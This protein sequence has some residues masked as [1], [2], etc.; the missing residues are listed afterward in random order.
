MLYLLGRRRKASVAGAPLKPQLL[1]THSEQTNTGQ[2]QTLKTA[3]NCSYTYTLNVEKFTMVFP[4]IDIIKRNEQSC[5][6]QAQMLYVAENNS[7]VH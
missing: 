2:A 3:I 7:Q 4:I 5:A 1:T 6:R